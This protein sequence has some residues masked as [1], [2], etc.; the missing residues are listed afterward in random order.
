[1]KQLMILTIVAVMAMPAIANVFLSFDDAADTDGWYTDRYAP[2]VFESGVSGGGRTG[3]LRHGISADDGADNRPSG[4]SGVFYNTQG[5]KYDLSGINE[6]S[7]ELYISSDWATTGRRMAGL[8]ATGFDSDGD[9]SLYPIIE[10]TS[11]N[12]NPRFQ[13]W[14]IDPSTGGFED[15]GLPTNFAYDEWYTLNIK[16][17]NSVTL[18][19]D[20]LTHTFPNSNETVEF[21]NVILQGHNTEDG[22]NYDIYWDNFAAVPEPATLSILGLGGLTLLGRKRR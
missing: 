2:A 8:W 6:M 9:V 5:M 10:F 7:I 20:D 18:S 12:D 15:L 19:V 1:M 13:A 22:V 4:F 3:V 21:G 14:P 17:G 16:L 11:D